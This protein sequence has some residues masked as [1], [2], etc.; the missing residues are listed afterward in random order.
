MSV[1]GNEEVEPPS[2]PLTMEEL[3][4]VRLM[5]FAPST[6]VDAAGD[7]ETSDDDKPIVKG[8]VNAE[9]V[10]V[11]SDTSSDAV[12]PD[13][14]EPVSI[15]RKRRQAS[16]YQEI[17]ANTPDEV[18]AALKV[19]NPHCVPRVRSSSGNKYF[20]FTCKH[21]VKGCALN[22][23]CV[24][25]PNGNLVTNSKVCV[26]GTCDSSGPPRPELKQPSPGQIPQPS[27]GP[28][29]QQCEQEQQDQKDCAV[30]WEALPNMCAQCSNGHFFCDKDF[31]Q[32][33]STQVLGNGK[34]NFVSL[35]N[36]VVCTYCEP[37][38]TIDMQLNAKF[39]ERN[40]WGRYLEAVTEAAV[41]AEQSRASKP[42]VAVVTELAAVEELM[43]N[44]CPHCKQVYSDFSG[45]LSLTCGN[46]HRNG[47]GNLVSLSGCGTMF[48]GYC[49]TIVNDE[50]ACHEHLRTSCMWNP[51]QS[52]VFPGRE[53]TAIRLQFKRERIWN[54]V[55]TNLSD[56]IPAIWS[57]ID[58]NF[59]E[60]QL[61][62]EW[63]IERQRWLDIAAEMQI[64]QATFSE[65]IAQITRCVTAM[66]EMGFEGDVVIR[67]TLL[68][69][70]N[71][72]T[73]VAALLAND[74]VLQSCLN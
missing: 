53:F 41:I 40:V 5:Y 33:V 26:A 67:A 42:D 11:S 50:F 74:A 56:K 44:K 10:T 16:M 46:W 36:V 73:T 3:R 54:H 37:P 14:A 31:S 34:A 35:G 6:V 30:C 22:A 49:D 62:A 7:A 47:E 20:R 13:A 63:L 59:P 32:M 51:R 45:C 15:P 66:T 2:R 28:P 65:G 52:T 29:L 48:C 8:I 69:K 27:T 61:T 72:E 68:N 64:S 1:D 17:S 24:R 38:T 19:T 57:T 18:V 25:R 70:A 4:R 23:T 58:Q 43:T 21:D 71:P 9:I 12:E 39:I 60:L 55:I